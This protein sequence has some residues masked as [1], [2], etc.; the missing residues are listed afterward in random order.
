[1]K[2]TAAL[3]VFGLAAIA[4]AWAADTQM[5]S[6]MD[7]SDHMNMDAAKTAEGSPSSK[8]FEAVNQKMH[9]EMSKPYTGD[10]D[11][12]FVNGMIA[13]HQGAIDMAKVQLQ[14]GKDP[15]M[16]KLAEDI[17]KAQEPEIAAMNAWVA[18]HKK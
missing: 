4:P 2:S 7:H 6:Q 12:D 5:K 9:A 18:K 11:V 3:I 8:A 16:R 13:H 15:E 17:I 14:Y 10:A 1:M